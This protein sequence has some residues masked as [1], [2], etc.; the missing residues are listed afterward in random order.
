MEHPSISEQMFGALRA[1]DVELARIVV[2]TNLGAIDARDPSGTGILL[3]ALYMRAELFVAMLLEEGATPD[4][5]SAAALGDVERL[6]EAISANGGSASGHSN[7]GWTALHLAAHFG[8][9]DVCAVLLSA[10][11]DVGAWS[12]NALRNQP[13]HA[14]VAG[15]SDAVVSLLLE[16]GADVN[17]VQHGGFTPLHGAAQ[18]GAERQVEALLARGADRTMLTEDGA[19]AGSIAKSAGFT[20]LAARLGV[21]KA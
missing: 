17:A 14:A 13:L 19:D 7:D 5:W 11:A 3:M 10:G 2:R 1:G 6:V 12:T 18:H 9:P 8:H 16:A 4:L 15:G 20:E 21:L